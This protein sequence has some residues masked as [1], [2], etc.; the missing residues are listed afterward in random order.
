M[1]TSELHVQPVVW[2]YR[3][4]RFAALFLEGEA[5]DRSNDGG[6][7]ADALFRV[8]FASGL[9]LTTDLDHLSLA[10]TSGWRAHLDEA[11]GLTLRWPHHTALLVDVAL[12]P[13]DGWAQ[14]AMGHGHVFVFVGYGLGLHEHAGDGAAHPVARMRRIAETGALAAGVVPF[15]MASGPGHANVPSQVVSPYSTT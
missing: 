10:P 7:R 2:S 13:P 6:L 12:D 11:G 8:A 14:A 4:E 1:A 3:G 15:T 5:P 9:R